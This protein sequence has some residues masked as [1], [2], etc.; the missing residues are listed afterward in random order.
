MKQDTYHHGNLKEE[1]IERGLEYIARYGT[2]SLSL[3]K[4]AE[5][6]GVSPAA[7]YAH[8][9]NKEAYLAAVREYITEKFY[10][11]LQEAADR[12]PEPKRVLLE[13]GKSYVIFF[14]KNPLYYQ[15]LFSRDDLETESYPPFQLFKGIAED[16]VKGMSAGNEEAT[17]SVSAGNAEAAPRA[18]ECNAAA[19]AHMSASASAAALRAKVIALWALVHGLAS[20]VT[21]KGAVDTDHLEEEIERILG[22]VRV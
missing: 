4:L 3:R 16:A 14:C 1:L 19:A 8:F 5:A 21:I 11:A 9:T 12:C 7:P 13:M 10:R 22:S 2:E 15:F 6:A 20:V 17:A 18:S